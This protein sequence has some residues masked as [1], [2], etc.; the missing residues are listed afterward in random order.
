MRRRK[1]HALEVCLQSALGTGV[2]A[3]GEHADVVGLMRES[4]KVMP[5]MAA[6][7]QLQNAPNDYNDGGLQPDT[8]PYAP[9]KL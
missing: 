7:A 2:V 5:E 6:Q 9:T 4:V 3:E 1:E 8:D